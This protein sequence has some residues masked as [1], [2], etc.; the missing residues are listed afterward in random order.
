MK[1]SLAEKLLG[2]ARLFR[3]DLMLII[4]PALVWAALIYSRPLLIHPRCIDPQNSCKTENLLKVDQIAVRQNSS[5]AD[6]YSYFTQNLSGVLAAATPALWS[7]GLAALGRLSPTSALVAISTDLV[8]LAETTVWNGFLGETV[9][10]IA[11]RPRPFVYASPADAGTNPS[12]YVSFY[13][14]HTSFAASAMTA[15]FL[16]LL[17]RK[18]P[19]P[20]LTG[21][22]AVGIALTLSTGLFRVLAGRH[23]VTDVVVATLA[24]VLVATAVALIHRK[25]D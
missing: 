25:L 4:I 3:W 9:R 22:G 17:G 2:P 23:F 8:I 24:G 19:R 16:I 5:Q 18:V 14:G 7:G 20:L 6:A 10:L 12:H 11:Q 1:P 15:L 13:S 21:F